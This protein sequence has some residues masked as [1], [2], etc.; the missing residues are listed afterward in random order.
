MNRIMGRTR[1]LLVLV[2]VLTIGTALFAGEFFAVSDSWILFPGSPHVYSAGNIGCGV[3]TD[4]NGILLMDMKNQREY[5]QNLA[6]RSATLHWL[7]D[8]NGNISAPALSNYAQQLVGYDPVNGVYGYGGVGGQAKLSLSAGAQIAAINAFGDYHGTIG[9]YNYKTGEILCAVTAPTFDPENPVDISGD[10]GNV[11]DG[12]YVNRFTQS[13]YTPG[14]IF[15]IATTAAALEHIPDILEQTFTCTGEHAYGVDKVTC[16]IGHGTMT[17][18]EAMGNSCNCAY[19][20]I[21]EQLGSR[22][23]SRYLEQFGILDSLEFDGILTAKGNVELK[24]LYAVELAWSA[25]GQHKDLLNPCAY[26]AFMGAIANGGVTVN[27]YI[28]SE[29]TV[30]DEVTYQAQTQ[31]TGRIMSSKTAQIL[32][33]FMRNN[34]VNYYGAPFEGLTVCAKT[35]TAEV[36]ESITDTAT[37]S[38]FVADDKYPL[39]FIVVVE[40]G[41]Y[42]LT[43]CEPILSKVL[44]ACVEDMDAKSGK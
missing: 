41:G 13:A 31:S 19:A 4:R 38:G 27:P 5:S 18:K 11:Y 28:V 20:M 26:M 44:A 12:I 30:G 17:F 2:L 35:G 3:I 21:A 23:L 32:R 7:G 14:S 37:F 43:A 16:Y 8:K 40:E 22:M 36:G 9:V 15:K 34:V 33:E 29:I 24:D 25:I 39:A 1:I 10:N 6:L 42:G